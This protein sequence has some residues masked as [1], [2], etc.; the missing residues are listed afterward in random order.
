MSARHGDSAYFFSPSGWQDLQPRS[1]EA[2][3][4][5]VLAYFGTSPSCLSF[6]FD[7]VCSPVWHDTQ[8]Q[9]DHCGVLWQSV[10]AKSLWSLPDVSVKNL[11]W[12][13]FVNVAGGQA[14][15][16]WHVSHAEES[17]HLTCDGL[18][19]AAKSGAWQPLQL[20]GMPGPWPPTW[21]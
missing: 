5:I 16:E 1:G 17:S 10:Q 2:A 6:I 3:A 20:V 13:V 21:H 7:S 18:V 19:V 14:A 4:A 9:S 8:I 12:T 11:S 15:V